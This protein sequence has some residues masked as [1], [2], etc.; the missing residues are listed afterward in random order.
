M[1]VDTAADP[2]MI[3]KKDGSWRLLC[4]IEDGTNATIIASSGAAFVFAGLFTRSKQQTRRDQEKM[5][6]EQKPYKYGTAV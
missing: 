2:S 5:W 3:D 4:G 1:E 6:A